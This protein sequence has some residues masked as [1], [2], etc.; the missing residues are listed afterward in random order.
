[1][2][3]PARAY[4]ALLHLALRQ[5]EAAE[6]GDLDAA[7]ALMPARAE[8]LANAGAPVGGDY[9]A[10]REVLRVDRDLASALRRKMIAIRDEAVGLQ[11]GRSALVGYQPPLGDRRPRRLNA[12]G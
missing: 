1:M 3:T 6:Q 8:L 4:T 10:I 7:I 12:L 9:D 11:H 5:L 2:D